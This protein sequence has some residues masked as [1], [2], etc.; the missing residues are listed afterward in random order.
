MENV[1]KYNGLNVYKISA[2][3]EFSEAQLDYV[4]LVDM[5]AIEI[6]GLYFGK[7]EKLDDLYKFNFNK[8]K[9]MVVGPAII[10]NKMIYRQDPEL[11]EF[12]VVF[13]EDTIERLVA[14][15]NKTPKEFKVNVDH[16][17]VVPSAFIFSNW[18]IEDPEKDKASVYGYDNLPK[19]TWFVEVKID[20]KE[21]WEKE[22]KENEKFGFSVEGIFGL[23]IKNKEKI[24]EQK[25]EKT[26]LVFAEIE[27]KEG[28]IWVEGELEVGSP[29]WVINDQLEKVA[30][31]G[32]FTMENGVV[33]K[34]QEGKI[35][36]IVKAEMEEEM[37]EEVM[38]PAADA[39][40]IEK[41][42]E[43]VQPKLDEIYNLI[44][45]LKS[46][47]EEKEV[48]EVEEVQPEMFT[49]VNKVISLTKMIKEKYGK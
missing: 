43:T 49:K 32:D 42:M 24:K 22:V 19:G 9:Q 16:S 6:K 1:E 39:L 2:D 15:F 7:Q 8:E 46:M 20:D 29:V 30:A 26:K 34:V 40:T 25:M 31:E 44:A 35:V 27:A 12:Y 47:M 10:P 13:D 5:P 4:S 48:V 11:G 38:E 23:K 36:E 33:I 17:S 45:E 3:E 37:A 41:V 18:I 14:K 28:K 21:F